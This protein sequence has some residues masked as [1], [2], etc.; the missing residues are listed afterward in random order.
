MG[1]SD[2]RVLKRVKWQIPVFHGETTSWRRFEMELLMA[3][4][5]LR[6]DSMLSGDK[7]EILV[8]NRTI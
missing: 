6:L 5:H 2:F 1:E 4:R 8:V 3:M 7:D